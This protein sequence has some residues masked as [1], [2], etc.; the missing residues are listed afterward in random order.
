MIEIPKVDENN[1][2]KIRNKNAKK[3]QQRFLKYLKK[4]DFEYSTKNSS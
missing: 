1:K 2:K 3:G 4:I